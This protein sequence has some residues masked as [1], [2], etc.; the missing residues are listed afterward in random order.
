MLD[1][2]QDARRHKPRGAHYATGASQLADL[3]GRARAADLDA[4][5]GALGLDDIFPRGA[6]AGVDQNL[7]EI[8]LCHTLQLFPTRA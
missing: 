1:Y 3:D 2:R 8:S 4:A 7:D 6:V 5:A